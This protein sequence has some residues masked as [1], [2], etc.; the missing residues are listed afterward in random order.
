MTSSLLVL[1]CLF[2]VDVDLKSESVWVGLVIAVNLLYPLI[3]YGLLSSFDEN[4]LTG[5]ISDSF[6]C[7]FFE[8]G[9]S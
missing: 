9:N 1:Y 7:S 8:L 6:C 5:L 3:N 2:L 4:G